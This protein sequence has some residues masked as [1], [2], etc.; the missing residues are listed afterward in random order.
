MITPIDKL[1]DLHYTQRWTLVGTNKESTVASHSFNVAMI[2]MDIRKRMFNTSDAS[3]MEVCFFALIHDVKETYTG[4][5]P[6]PTKARIKEEGVDVNALDFGFGDELEPS[7]KIK[8]IIKAADL[9]ENY[10]FIKGHGTGTRATVAKDEVGERLS[11]FLSESA[12]DLQKAAADTMAY[13]LHRRSDD[14]EERKRIEEGRK[15]RNLFSQQL[16][17]TRVVGRES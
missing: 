13:I 10:L 17:V 14:P 6:T 4:D 1:M 9:I 8:S 15:T 5:M 2:A 11:K 16:A 3:E 12:D 7:K